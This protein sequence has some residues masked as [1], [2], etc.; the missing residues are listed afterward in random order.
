MLKEKINALTQYLPQS[1]GLLHMSEDKESPSPFLEDSVKALYARY[2]LVDSLPVEAV[3]TA[4]FSMAHFLLEDNSHVAHMGCGSGEET[5]AMACLF[6]HLRFTGI[7][8]NKDLIKKAKKSFRR[9]NLQFLEG[10]VINDLPFK[11]NSLD[12]II[13]SFLLHEIYSNSRYDDRQVDEA[14][15][16]QFSLLRNE[17]LLYIRDFAQRHAG[18]YVLMEMPDHKSK[19]DKIE[20]LSEADLLVWLSEKARPQEDP[21]CHGFFLEELPPRFPQTRLFRLPY[22]WAYEFIIRKDRRDLLQTEL[23]QEYT[24]F[25]EREYRKRMRAL[26]ARALY[27]APHWDDIKI[28]DFYEGHFRLYDD[29]AVPLG[30]PPTSYILLAQKVEKQKSLNL[31]ERRP[32]SKGPENLTITTMRN[33]QTGKFIDIATRDVDVTEVLPYRVDNG[34][35]F[36]YVHESL[37]RGIVNAVPRRGKD[38]DGKRWSGHMIE[39]ISIPGDVIHQLEH[40]DQKDLK[41]FAKD[42]LDLTPLKD[43]RLEEGM[44]FYPDP[45]Y[46]NELI[47]TRFL[48]VENH[49]GPIEPRYTMDDIKGFTTRGIYRKERAQ[50]I[51]NGIAVGL[52]PSARLELQII[53]LYHKLGMVAETWVESPLRL[54]ETNPKDKFSIRDFLKMRAE[55]DDRFKKVRGSAGQ[56]RPVKS[57]FIDEGWVEGGVAGMAS[58][59]MEFVIPEEDTLNKAT[60]IPLTKNAGKAVMAMELEYMPVPQRFENNGLMMKAPCINLPKDIGNIYQAKKFIAEKFGVPVENVWRLGESYLTHPSVTPQRIF[61]FALATTDK[62]QKPFAG[63]TT[64]APMDYIW[65]VLD[66]YSLFFMD[67]KAIKDTFKVYRILSNSSDVLGNISKQGFARSYPLRID[68]ATLTSETLSGLEKLNINDIKSQIE[69]GGF[70]TS[71]AIADFSRSGDINAHE[72]E[73]GSGDTGANERNAEETE[74]EHNKT[75]TNDKKRLQFPSDKQK[76]KYNA[77]QKTEKSD[78][79]SESKREKDPSRDL[80]PK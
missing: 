44:P 61:P 78:K 73:E 69:K 15:N 11:E 48:Y 72:D 2:S 1:K 45:D 71:T 55:K 7:D 28:N 4:W 63:T 26:G 12:G 77:R 39:A 23:H 19:G 13:N 9:P 37:P 22:K 40:E 6:P 29:N 79:K 38:L 8:V 50:D 56:L 75:S 53:E 42:Y 5:Y 76:G 31:Q 66:N 47:K 21:S 18:E 32:S 67:W 16:Y 68:P 43:A 70:E 3:R 65:D 41:K 33:S 57:V 58:R 46:I 60:I 24:F 34:E 64:Y 80:N 14:I 36:I 17:G 35:L 52:I 54:E 49:E 25:T 30:H 51:L 10:N 59:D 27:A 20:D 62:I 74:T